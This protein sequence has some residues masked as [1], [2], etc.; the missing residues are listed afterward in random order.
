MLVTCPN[1]S[2]RYSVPDRVVGMK[3]RTMRCSRCQHQWEQPFVATQ[4][5]PPRRQRS[6]ARLVV[7]PPRQRAPAPEASMPPAFEPPEPIEDDLLAAAMRDEERGDDGGGEESRGPNPF[8]RIAEMMMEQ[9][10]APV[11]DLFANSGGETER[12]RRGTLGLIAVAGVLVVAV[13]AVI[14]YFMQDRVINKYPAAA[15][16]YDKLG[17]RNEIPGAGLAFR[18][19]GVERTG[20]D[21]AEVLVVR[22]VIANTTDRELPIPPMHLVLFDGQNPVQ[23]KSI[24]PPQPKLDGKGTVGFKVTL[25]QPDPHATRFEVNFEAPK[26]AEAAPAK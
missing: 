16:F 25:D 20:K 1:C 22:G 10:P 15:H 11:P 5:E 24:D 21:N 23:D 8:D 6:E 4:P 26:K 12:R 3:G 17:A 9:P 14:L 13:I 7:D 18:D 2:A 19:I